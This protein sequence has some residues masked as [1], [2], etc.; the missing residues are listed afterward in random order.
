LTDFLDIEGCLFVDRVVVDLYFPDAGCHS[1]LSW[2]VVRA[3]FGIGEAPVYPGLSAA[4]RFG[5]P[6]GSAEKPSASWLEEPSWTG[7]WDSVSTLIMVHW[8]GRA[9]FISFGVLE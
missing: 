4:L 6:S 3:L 1:L 9:V 8:D 7:D 5:F 2:I